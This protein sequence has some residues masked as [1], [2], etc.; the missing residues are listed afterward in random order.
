ML[1]TCKASGKPINRFLSQNAKEAKKKRRRLERCW[2]RTGKES[3]HRAYRSQCR[4]SNSLINESRRQYFAERISNFNAGPKKCWSTV[5]E[6]LHTGKHNVVSE[7]EGEQRCTEISAY[8][9]EKNKSDERH[10]CQPFNWTQQKSVPVRQAT[11]WSAT[12]LL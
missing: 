8:F 5:N 2:K 11:R 3:D 4:L 6:L 12:E 10:R 7:S 9:Q 1:V